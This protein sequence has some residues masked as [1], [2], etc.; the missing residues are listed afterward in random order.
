MT[1]RTKT[2]FVISLLYSV[3][4]VLTLVSI[5]YVIHIQGTKL[6]DAKIAIA[7]HAAKELAYT[8]VMQALVSSEGDRAK[9]GSFVMSDKDIIPFVTELE[10][11]A[12]AFGVSMQTTGLSVTPAAGANPPVLTVGVH[13]S[14][15][16][17][18]VKKYITL[19]E[20]VPY[21]KHISTFT[22]SGDDVSN[23]WVADT[24]LAITMKP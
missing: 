17:A 16:Q 1:K 13:I 11:T 5:L 4:L 2:T 14:G 7:E 12:K 21:H 6:G 18:A 15:G 3:V 10:S 19:L 22:F 8:N 9:L 20:N 24:S 23:V